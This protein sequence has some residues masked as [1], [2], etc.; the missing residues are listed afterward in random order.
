VAVCLFTRTRAPLAEL[1]LRV[2]PLAGADA[3]APVGRENGHGAAA[4][5]HHRRG[6]LADGT[7]VKI[8]TGPDDYP[9]TGMPGVADRHVPGGEKTTDLGRKSRA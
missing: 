9:A 7:E 2:A 3:A 1:A 8:V 4:A 5:G 6:F